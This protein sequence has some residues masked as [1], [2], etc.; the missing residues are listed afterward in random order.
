MQSFV[1]GCIIMGVVKKS[2]LLNKAEDF[3]F[4]GLF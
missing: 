2:S 1:Y 4:S 3:I